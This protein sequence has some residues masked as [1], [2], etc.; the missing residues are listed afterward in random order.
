MARPPRVVDLRSG[1][2]A[3]EE[4]PELPRKREREADRERRRERPRERRS[5]LKERKR[6]F[7]A[8]ITAAASVCALLTAYA[9]HV[10]SYMP[11]FTFQH[12]TVTGTATMDAALMQQFVE[13]ELQNE[14]HGFISGRNIF[15]YAFRP[16]ER[17]IMAHNPIVKNARVS[18]DTSLGNGIIVDIEERNPYARWCTEGGS[19]YKMDDTGLVFAKL[20]VT[21]TSSLASP[22]IFSGKLSTTT[23]PSLAEEPLGDTFAGVHFVGITNLLRGLGQ[24]GHIAYGASLQNEQDFFIPLEDGFYIKASYGENPDTLVKNLNLVLSSDALKDKKADLEYVDLRFGNK[25]YYKL[26]GQVAVGP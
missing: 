9:V 10:A 13:G 15:I 20:G 18:R 21:P 17:S 22:Y 8:V 12:V 26:K 5:A 16:L 6:R 23:P 3:P 2:S 11:Q 1:K 14:S 24:S 19:C 25:V 4:M 7:R